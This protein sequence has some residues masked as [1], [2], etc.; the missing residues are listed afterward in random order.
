MNWWGKLIGS[1]IGLLGGPMG[2]L[3]GAAI[4]HLYDEDDVTPQDEKK[5]RILYI[6][7]FFSC[8]SKIAKADGRISAREISA[9]E[10][11]MDRMGLNNKTKEFAKNVFRKAKHSRRSIDEE[12]REVGK[13]IGFDQVVGQSFLGGL[14]EIVI[15]NETKLNNLQLKY[16]QRAEVCLKLPN[17]IVRSWVNGGYAPPS[18]KIDPNSMSLN[19]AYNI[20]GLKTNSSDSEIK[21]AYRKR[22][23]NFH[24]DKLKS[25]NLPDEFISFANDQLAKVNQAYER[26][27]KE[28]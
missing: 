15:S 7:Y 22:A 17:G 1:G 21:T 6:A 24:P 16:L 13:L 8:A 11:I 27:K 20:L 25:K 14:F 5:A 12:F 18:Y 2:A 10:S 28:G 9:T 3:V 26:I 23:A 19:E 4:G